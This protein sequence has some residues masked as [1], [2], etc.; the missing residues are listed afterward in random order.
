[1]FAE[2][3]EVYYGIKCNQ[4]GILDGFFKNEHNAKAYAKF[5]DEQY[6]HLL[7]ELFPNGHKHTVFDLEK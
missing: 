5:S 2:E 7:P 1:M 6:G 4:C 3:V